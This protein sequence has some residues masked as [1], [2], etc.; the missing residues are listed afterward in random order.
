[1]GGGVVRAG[2]AGRGERGQGVGGSAA[3]EDSNTSLYKFLCVRQSQRRRLRTLPPPLTR[4]SSRSFSVS[5]GSPSRTRST[6]DRWH[7]GMM[8]MSACGKG[9]GEQLRR[10]GVAAACGGGATHRRRWCRGTRGRRL[11][12]SSWGRLQ[13]GAHGV[14]VWEGGRL[15]RRAGACSHSGSSTRE[16]P[17]TWASLAPA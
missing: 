17:T 13:F 6:S 12:R 5:E 8:S 14:R 4:S 1:M 11:L 16:C 15:R 2:G 7:V 3:P 9:D 10:C